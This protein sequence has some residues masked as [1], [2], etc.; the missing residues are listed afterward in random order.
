MLGAEIAR[1]FESRRG[2]ARVADRGEGR[3]KEGKKRCIFPH[4]PSPSTIVNFLSSSPEQKQADNDETSTITNIDPIFRFS[5][6][7]K[8]TTPVRI[9]QQRR[10]PERPL[11]D[12]PH[13]ALCS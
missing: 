1:F 6:G 2:F 5:E 13:A 4:Y 9:L 8:V 12:V 3:K 11:Y 7:E 10:R